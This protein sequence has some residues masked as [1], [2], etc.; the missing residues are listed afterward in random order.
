[1][2]NPHHYQL[3]KMAEEYRLM[4][5]TGDDMH[6]KVALLELAVEYEQEALVDQQDRMPPPAEPDEREPTRSH[7]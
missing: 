4:S 6:L 1:M 2:A 3:L 5:M 7:Y